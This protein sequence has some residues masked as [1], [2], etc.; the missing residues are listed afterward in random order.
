MGPKILKAMG[1]KFYQ[2]VII[3]GATAAAIKTAFDNWYLRGQ[4]FNSI[5]YPVIVSATMF[6]V[7]D[8]IVIYYLENE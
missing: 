3:T 2:S 8:L 5:K 4:E 7:T 6:G 1:K